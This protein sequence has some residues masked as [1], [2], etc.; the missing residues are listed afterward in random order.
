MGL[1]FKAGYRFCHEW[2]P[3][4]LNEQKRNYLLIYKRSNCLLTHSW[5]SYYL[6]STMQTCLWCTLRLYKNSSCIRAF[7]ITWRFAQTM[8]RWPCWC[9]KPPRRRGGGG[10]VLL[11]ITH[12]G[13]C[14]FKGQGFWVSVWNRVWVRGNYGGLWTFHRFNSWWIRMKEEICEFEVDF[15][16]SLLLAT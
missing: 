15:K 2:D 8:K 10:G 13:L 6:T 11:Y 5:W 7:H 16:K 12:I 14:R 4:G 3:E 9:L 1:I